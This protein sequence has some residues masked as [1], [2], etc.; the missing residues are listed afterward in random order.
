MN[1]RTIGIDIAKEVFQIHGVDSQGKVLVKKQI[2]RHGMLKFFANL[3]PCCV[4][5]RPV[6]G[7]ITG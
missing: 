2:R 3:Q 6:A 1:I 5:W 7:S 4:A